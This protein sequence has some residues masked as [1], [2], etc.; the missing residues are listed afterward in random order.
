M[1]TIEVIKVTKKRLA[2]LFGGR[3]AEHEVSVDSANNIYKAI[4]KEKYEVIVIGIDHKGKWYLYNKKDLKNLT[5]PDKK[6]DYFEKLA[7]I[8][9][10]NDKQFYNLEKNKFIKKIDVI[11]P[12]LHGPYGEDG[13]IQGLIKNIDTPFVGAGV[14]ASAIAMDK[15]VMKRLLSE[16][17]INIADYQV[18]KNNKNYEANNLINKLGLPLFV[19][20]ANLGSSVG[21]KKVIKKEELTN[22][23]D[24]ALKFDNKVIVE[25]F[26]KGREIECSVLGNEKIK[27]SLPGEIIPQD[28][29][30]SYEAKY[31]NDQ[32]AVL[33]FPAEL[34]DELTK[35]IKKISLKVYKTL[36]TEGMARVDCFLK[37]DGEI[38]VN[39]I[40]T[41]PG[42]TK[43]SMYPKLWEISGIGYSDLI[44][45]LIELAFKRY[46]KEIKLKNNYN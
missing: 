43:I 18:I 29:F 33:S 9:G 37:E 10:N 13:T 15:G 12:V 20:P 7:L 45:H 35:K 8:P 4:N 3:S 23:I 19:K 25:E 26:I 46:E 11:F 16:E 32:G 28:D 41:I 36:L 30:Y 27:A 44:N 40:N 31:I 38:I 5:V 39:E 34:S 6:E 21:V 42:F 17:N 22:A 1:K 24:Y 14:L 2:I